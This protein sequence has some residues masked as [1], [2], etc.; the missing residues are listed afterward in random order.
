M[1]HDLSK[2]MGRDSFFFPMQEPV[3][4]AEKSFLNWPMGT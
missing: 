2:E 4:H 3:G 1:A